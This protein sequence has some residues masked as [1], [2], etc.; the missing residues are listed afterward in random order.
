MEN[1]FGDIRTAR[2]FIV[3]RRFD[4]VILRVEIKVRRI[5]S[6][7]NLNELNLARDMSQRLLGKS[8]KTQHLTC[9]GLLFDFV[10]TTR[11]ITV[12]V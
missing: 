2:N 12:V 9:R 5:G 4:G 3:H 11:G 8:Q 1:N 7:S 6:D 10:H